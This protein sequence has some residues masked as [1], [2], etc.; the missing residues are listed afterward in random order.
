MAIHIVKEHCLAS[1]EGFE[2]TD[3]PDPLFYVV[4]LEGG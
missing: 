4:R 1:P 2:P 3:I